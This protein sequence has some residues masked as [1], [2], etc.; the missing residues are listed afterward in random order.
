MRLA[1]LVFRSGRWSLYVVQHG[2]S[3]WPTHTFTG[4]AVPTLTERS[5]ALK[6]LGFACRTAEEWS[7]V[8]DCEEFAN[9]DS[10]I[11][12]IAVTGVTPTGGGA[13]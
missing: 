7:W 11:V 10:P 13:A 2:R 8:E 4:A 6:A 12:L 1:H 9:P 5:R 3:S